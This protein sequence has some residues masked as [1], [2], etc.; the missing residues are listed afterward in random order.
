MHDPL[1]GITSRGTITTGAGRERIADI[2]RPVLDAALIAVRTADPDASLYVY[3]S[4]ATGMAR[5]GESDVDLLT[6][7]VPADAAAEMGRD[8]SLRFSGICASVEVAAAQEGDFRG[9][10]DAAY[11]GRVF[12]RH[13]CVHLAG[14]DVHAGLPDFPA[15]ARAARGFNGDIGEH[16]RRWRQ[17]LDHGT[18]PAQ[19]SRRIA[20]KTLHAVAGLVSV[21]DGTWTTDRMAAAL[22]W[23]QIDPSLV[24]DLETLLDWSTGGVT[25]DRQS[26]GEML[27]GGVSRVVAVFESAIGLWDSNGR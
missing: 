2:F 21:H 25:P 14:P 17:E 6:I 26:I 4:V 20:R 7:G 19:L 16:V 15:D 10:G 9:D 23:S 12:L 1:E 13:Y 11:G 18:D 8:L 5:P 24:G 3:G 27:D 22:R